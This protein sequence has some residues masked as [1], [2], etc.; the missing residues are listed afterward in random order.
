MVVLDQTVTSKTPTGATFTAHDLKG[1]IY[2]GRVITT[3]P[4]HWGR[5]GSLRLVFDDP[6]ATVHNVP[7]KSFR[8]HPG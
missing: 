6:A 8:E 7:G 4:R 1:T 2:A 3:P 5:R